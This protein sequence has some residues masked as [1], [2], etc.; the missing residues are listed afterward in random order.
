MADEHPGNRAG[1]AN[2][3]QEDPMSMGTPQEEP[4]SM[5]TPSDTGS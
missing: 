1:G 4:M 5:D 2:I 3:Q